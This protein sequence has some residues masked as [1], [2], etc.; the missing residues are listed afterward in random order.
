MFNVVKTKKRKRKK[1]ATGS[2]QYHTPIIT[3][4]PHSMLNIGNILLVPRRQWAKAHIFLLPPPPP[5]PFFSFLFF[6]LSS[7]L[8]PWFLLI[9]SQIRTLLHVSP[10]CIM[11]EDWVSMVSSPKPCAG[12][13]PRRKKEKNHWSFKTGAHTSLLYSKYCIWIHFQP[14]SWHHVML[15]TTTSINITIYKMRCVALQPRTTLLLLLLLLLLLC[16]CV[17]R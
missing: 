12:L 10:S 9:M 8:P 1:N 13:K 2:L 5:P 16:V 7:F 4:L 14:K 3:A 11:M 6:F 15:K 17:P